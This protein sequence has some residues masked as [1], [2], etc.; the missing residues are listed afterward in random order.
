MAR[1]NNLNNF[2]TDVANAIRSKKGISNLIPAEDFDTEI[3][4]ITTGG[5]MQSKSI[6][7]TE[8]GSRT[9][10]PDTGY[11][12]LSSVSIT[13]SVPGGTTGDFEYDN[14]IAYGENQPNVNN[15]KYWLPVPTTPTNTPLKQVSGYKL[16]SYFS[17]DIANLVNSSTADSYRSSA[18][19]PLDVVYYNGVYYYCSQAVAYSQTVSRY[20]YSNQNYPM[21]DITS[22]STST[23]GMD[24]S[25]TI[26]T[27]LNMT[28]SS[29]QQTSYGAWL[30]EDGTLYYFETVY[31]SSS[32]N[33]RVEY[34][35]LSGG[36]TT[37]L[38]CGKNYLALESQKNRALGLF[39]IDSTHFLLLMYNTASTSSLK[40]YKLNCSTSTS[41]ASATLLKSYSMSNAQNYGCK[42]LDSN[43][44]LITPNGTS[45]YSTSTYYVIV[46]DVNDSNQSY[47]MTYPSGATSFTCTYLMPQNKLVYRFNNDNYKLYEITKVD[48]IYR[49]T[50]MN[51]GNI[52]GGIIA[53][54]LSSLL[55]VSTTNNL[56]RARCSSTMSFKYND[57]S[58]IAQ[59][60][61][62]TQ[63]TNTISYQTNNNVAITVEDIE[64]IDSSDNVLLISNYLG[65]ASNIHYKFYPKSSSNI[66]LPLLRDY[67]DGAI[68]IYNKTVYY[69]KVSK[70]GQWISTLNDSDNII[71]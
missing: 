46:F 2:L 31:I 62:A 15:Y 70:N 55:Y 27:L 33:D 54:G 37:Y 28:P 47:T 57:V 56:F 14:W 36:S 59:F 61:N 17:G 58:Y 63:S 11:D 67:N 13:T 40:I 6:T 45:S 30:I 53:Q 22:T 24:R 20:T 49:F 51:I 43:S 65:T 52:F 25:A 38:Y 50:E 5:D 7:I 26:K 16:A 68:I 64:N 4:S 41:G 19:K 23:S 71:Q 12:G 1:I 21:A 48:G 10:T 42:K 44:M 34:R 69:L 39:K 3:G 66:F 60:E 35:S 9:I 18:I 8:N 32:G 29:S